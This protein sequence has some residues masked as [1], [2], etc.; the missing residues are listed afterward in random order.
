MKSEVDRRRWINEM[1]C[2]IAFWMLLKALRNAK[3]SS[4][5]QLVIFAHELRS[6]L[7]LTGFSN[8]NCEV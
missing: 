2:L 8:I 1:N 4:D 6:A 7:R 5:E 3:I